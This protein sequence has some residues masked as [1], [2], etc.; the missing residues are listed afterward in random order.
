MI[1]VVMFIVLVIVMILAVV[2][3]TTRLG[4]LSTQRV[5]ID[6]ISCLVDNSD[7]L[8]EPSHCFGLTDLGAQ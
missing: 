6:S 1:V 4:N 8:Y 5:T 2:V 3:L 7:V